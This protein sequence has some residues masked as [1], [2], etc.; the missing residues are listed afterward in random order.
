MRLMCLIGRHEY[1]TR[2]ESGETYTVCAECGKV[3]GS[4][5]DEV[6]RNFDNQFQPGDQWTRDKGKQTKQGQ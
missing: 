2:S 3:G 1:V 5:G 6:V 4:P